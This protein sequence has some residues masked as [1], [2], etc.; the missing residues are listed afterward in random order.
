MHDVTDLRALFPRLHELIG[1]IAKTNPRRSYFSNFE[2]SITENPVKQKHFTH[3]ESDLAGL[4]EVAWRHLKTV[5]AKKFA[6]PDPQRGWLQAFDILNEAKA[7]NY[8]VRLGCHDVTF[9]ATAATKMPDLQA[10]LGTTRVLCEVKTINASAIEIRARQEA[11]A[12]DIQGSLPEVF[13]KKLRGRLKDAENQLNAFGEGADI[14]LITYV[15]L[16][17]DDNLNEHVA[18]YMEYVRDF[19]MALQPSNI[20]IVFDVKLAYYSATAESAPRQL[21]VCARD[22]SWLRV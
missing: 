20:D 13:F 4:G 5:V 16:N 17:F 1:S 19:S 9:L 2:E 21:F 6:Q 12:R 18:S 7:Y 11:I 8:L 14:H 22:R 3:I 10:L 15:V